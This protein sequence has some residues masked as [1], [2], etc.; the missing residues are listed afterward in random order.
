MLLFK[1][2]MLKFGGFEYEIANTEGG[3]Y[4]IIRQ[5][6]GTQFRYISHGF[7]NE[8]ELVTNRRYIPTK[9]TDGD[10]RRICGRYNS[11]VG[12]QGNIFYCVKKD[13]CFLKNI[14]YWSISYNEKYYKFYEVGRKNEGT[15][16]CV[17]LEDVIVSMIKMNPKIVYNSTQ[18]EIFSEK[19]IPLELVSI[20]TLF[21]D[22]IRHYPESRKRHTISNECRITIQKELNE[23]YNCDFISK[24]KFLEGI[25]D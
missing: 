21:I 1:R 17:Y 22:L 16:Y 24:I 5:R 2:N 9:S 13:F 15:F 12:N 19:D 3:I 4:K 23:K 10:S 7:D 25:N 11:R 8:F 18:Y 6:D 14:S 20:I